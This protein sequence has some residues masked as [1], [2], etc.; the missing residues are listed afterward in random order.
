MYHVPKALLG[1]TAWERLRH[2]EGEKAWREREMNVDNLL[3]SLVC[4]RSKYRQIHK[5]NVS[6]STESCHVAST[7][8][9]QSQNGT[10]PTDP[11]TDELRT[12]PPPWTIGQGNI[13]IVI[14][15]NIEQNESAS[16]VENCYK[17]LTHVHKSLHW[18]TNLNI[19]EKIQ[20]LHLH[21][22][23]FYGITKKSH[24]GL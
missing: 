21:F 12:R 17:C 6:P 13:L 9:T 14:K 1:A 24:M 15:N 5:Y 18:L 8:T 2:S 3:V 16:P 19:T 20:L 11:E 4:L 23:F 10:R 7:C 22:F